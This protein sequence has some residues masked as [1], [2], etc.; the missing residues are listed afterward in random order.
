MTLQRDT[1]REVAA[2]IEP[3]CFSCKWYLFWPYC[4]AFPRGIPN[5]IRAGANRHQAPITGDEGLVYER[6]TI[7]AVKEPDGKNNL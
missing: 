5:D 3:P 1:I 7:P 6:V 4:C 2:I